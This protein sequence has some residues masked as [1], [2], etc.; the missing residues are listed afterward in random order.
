MGKH[1][2]PFRSSAKSILLLPLICF[3]ALLFCT[4][5]NSDELYSDVFLHTNSI[6]IEEDTIP[7]RN[8]I[9]MLT[10]NG[11][12]FTGVQSYYFKNTDQL[13][14]SITF[15][16]GIRVKEQMFDE[17]GNE[18]Y[19]TEIDYDFE[20]NQRMSV[21]MYD[22]QA[23]SIEIIDSSSEHSGMHL[24]TEWHSNGQLKFESTSNELGSQGL[25]TLYDQNGNILE[26]E[27]YKDGELV[28]KIK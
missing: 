14:T 24:Y 6:T 2:S 5:S 25:M 15:K 10:R 27:L 13:F 21:R 11:E 28:E 1:P 19:R 20:S 26:Q 17:E 23:L 16:N 8:E 4:Q 22:E 9:I 12:P 7:A 18:K 3:F